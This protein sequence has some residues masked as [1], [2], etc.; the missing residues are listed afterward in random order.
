MLEWQEAQA[1]RCLRLLTKGESV[2]LGVLTFLLLAV[3]V[4]GCAGIGAASPAPTA[5]VTATLTATPS[6]PPSPTIL[7]RRPTPRPTP[8]PVIGKS[9]FAFLRTICRAF[10]ARDAGTIINSLPYFQYNSGL[11]YGNLGDG[12]GQTGDPGLMRTWLAQHRARCVYFT[13]DVAGHGTVL[14]RGW[15]VGGMRWSLIEL[16]TF[17]GHW[18]INDFTF[19]ARRNLWWAMQSSQPVLAYRG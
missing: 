16:D 9:Y 17:Q 2:R 14:T 5:T 1:K 15:R 18:K 4:S 11:R 6:P 3:A 8:T 12:E 7:P 10:S 19:G 13:P